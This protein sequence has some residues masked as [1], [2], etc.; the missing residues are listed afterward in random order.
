MQGYHTTC[1][2]SDW[3]LFGGIFFHYE[4]AM[5]PVSYEHL[6][7]HHHHHFEIRSLVQVSFKLKI[8][9]NFWPSWFS[10]R[11]AGMTGV[12]ISSARD[13]QCVQNQNTVHA[14]QILLWTE[15][16]S[17]FWS[18][19]LSSDGVSLQRQILVFKRCSEI[20]SQ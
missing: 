3:L 4:E 14:R 19:L 15:L 20:C 9:L 10:L 6:Y 18:F 17:Q 11:N 5:F 12:P 7:H 13:A 8:T 16:P 1:F 2:F